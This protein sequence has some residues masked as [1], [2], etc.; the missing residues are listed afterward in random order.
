MKIVILDG[1]T[2]NPGDLRW[3]ALAALGDLTVY[4]RTAKGEIGGRIAGAEVVFTNKTP[5]DEQIL[6]DADA[7]RFIG[8]L[9]TGYNIVDL[10]AARR[11]GIPVANIP[12]YAT[13]AVAQFTIALMLELCFHVGAHDQAVHRGDWQR[14]PDFSF[15][16]A[17]IW[18]LGGKT[19]GLIGYGRIG[20]AVARIARA[21]D[22][23]VL[24][25]DGP[26]QNAPAHAESAAVSF[27]R[28]LES[29]DIVSLHCPLTPE[30]TG[31]IGREALA[32]MKQGA[33]LINTARGPL[34]D[35]VAL[36]DALVS[37]HLGGAALD[38]VSAEPIDPDNPLLNAPR[39]LLTPHI[40][41]SA[42]E[43]RARLTEI[44]AEN[45]KAFLDGTP[46]NIVN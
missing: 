27:N 14:C 24:Y 3:D 12:T 2:T 8:V 44:A 41:W 9:A 22:M 39:C 34:I 42:K 10:T 16:V 5:L 25:Y 33:L 35:E 32:Q 28:L 45:L 15:T 29:S 18:E 13:G 20:Q 21:M 30:N 40:A 7:L 23:Q 31:I 17:P 38:V 11:K 1:F 36:R 19:L 46:Q 26:I 4:E 43:A 6:S 37:G